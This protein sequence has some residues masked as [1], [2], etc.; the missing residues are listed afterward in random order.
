VHGAGK[1]GTREA[2]TSASAASGRMSAGASGPLFVRER[3]SAR[4]WWAFSDGCEHGAGVPVSATP[5]KASVRQG[6][7]RHIR[8]MTIWRLLPS[9]IRTSWV[10]LSGRPDPPKRKLPRGMKKVGGP[11]SR[12]PIFRVHAL[13]SRAWRRRLLRNRY[14]T[15]FP[16]RTVI[17]GTVSRLGSVVVSCSE[18]EHRLGERRW[19]EAEREVPLS[20]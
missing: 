17:Q 7:G 5:P 2:P 1:P 12:P 10:Y 18:S 13:S 8:N 3:T 4:F 19:V 9:Q 11:G 20:G 15:S 16:P 14:W 6:R